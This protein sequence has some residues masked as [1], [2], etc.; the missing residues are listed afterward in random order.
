M[1]DVIGKTQ[2]FLRTY[3]LD[4][5]LVDVDACAR[6]FQADMEKG[7]RG[8]PDAWMM[9]LPTYL[10]LDGD[11]PKDTPTIVIDAGG[12]NFRI[13]LVTV[14]DHGPVVEDLRVLSLIHI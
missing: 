6:A 4:P 3:G 8:D 9:M 5:A 12:T 2:D 11:I 10:S 14:T 1:A 7:L 13:G